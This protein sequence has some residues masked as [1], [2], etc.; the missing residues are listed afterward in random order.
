MPSL[1]FRTRSD[2]HPPAA[3]AVPASK[4]TAPAQAG[5]GAPREFA[6]GARE[7]KEFQPL[8]TEYGRA[9]QGELGKKYDIATAAGFKE[10]AAKEQHQDAS[11]WKTWN[12]KKAGSDYLL[13]FLRHTASDI[14]APPDLSQSLAL[15][16]SNY[17]VSSSHNT[18]LSGHQ[19]YGE[20]SIDP[21]KNVL[22]RG[23]R[24]FA[25]Y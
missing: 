14:L 7:V 20:S 12:Y 4:S 1:P 6:E 3:R 19:L 8:L 10:F 25:L 9:I 23:C 11:E 2:A 17:F 24:M 15:P 5:G 22:L 13:N 18:Y 16:M 21:Y